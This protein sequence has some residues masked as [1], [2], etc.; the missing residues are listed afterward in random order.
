MG[1]KISKTDVEVQA[2]I[3]KTYIIHLMYSPEGNSQFCF[4]GSPDI[5]RDEVEGNIRTL[6]NTKLTSFP[7]NHT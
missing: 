3:I 1:K 4:P 5:S 7:R 6:G 2:Y